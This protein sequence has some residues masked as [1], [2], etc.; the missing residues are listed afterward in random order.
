MRAIASGG[1]RVFNGEVMNSFRIP[2]E[3]VNAVS[4]EELIELQ[5]RERVY[6]DESPPSEVEG[7]TVILIDDGIATGSTMLAS[8][9]ALRQLNAGSVVVAAPSLQRR[10]IMKSAA[11]RMM[12][13]R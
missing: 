9:S 13:Q 3:V 5:R 4:A 11:W 2:D 8:I 7:K 10:P 1:V 6:R 12:S